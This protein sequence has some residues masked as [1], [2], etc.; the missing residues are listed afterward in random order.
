M[1]KKLGVWVS[2]IL[3]GLFLSRC[4]LWP[5]SPPRPM[6]PPQLVTDTVFVHDTMTVTEYVDRWRVEHD[7]INLVR[8]VTVYDTT[9]IACQSLKPRRRIISAVFGEV[10]GDSTLVLSETQ[11]FVNDSLAFQRVIENIW[12]N[13]MPSRISIDSIGTA[14]EWRDFPTQDNSI[15]FFKKIEWML[16]GIGAYIVIDKAAQ[17]GKGSSSSRGNS[18]DH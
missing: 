5:A 7:T 8:T 18:D 1:S 16:K 6:P 12:T 2:L 15:S 9:R 14:I 13:G 4:V 17:I 10:Y 3:V 11:S